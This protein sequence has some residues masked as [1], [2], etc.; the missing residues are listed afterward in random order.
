MTEAALEAL[1][2][3]EREQGVRVLLAVESGSRAW[4]F[5][6][7]DSDY[8]VRFIYVHPRDWYLR[9]L[10]QRDVIERMLPGDLDLS[11]WEL[12]KALRLFAKCNLALNEWIGS[13]IVYRDADGFRNQL[14]SLVPGY[15]NAITGLHHYRRMASAALEGH[16]LD[17]RIGIKKIFYVLRPMLASRWIEHAKS[18]PPTEFVK[19]LAATWVTPEERAWISSLLEKKAL[20]KEADPIGLDGDRERRLRDELSGYESVAASLPAA[21]KADLTLLD[22]IMRVR[23]R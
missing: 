18:Q 23:V 9:V 3:I 14:A 4:G 20:A 17:G 10:D 1:V 15:F 6:S 21:G 12:R 16:L 13:P 2:D 19:L 11:G 8:D 22:E 5:A 7:P